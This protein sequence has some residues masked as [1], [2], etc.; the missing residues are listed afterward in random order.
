[1]STILAHPYRPDRASTTHILSNL[2]PIRIE[3][4][5]KK[6]VVRASLRSD[7]PEVIDNYYKQLGASDKALIFWL[8]DGSIHDRS[9]A[10]VKEKLL[11]NI[12]SEKIDS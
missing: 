6:F 10:K 1:M 11:G 4:N 5:G 2:S 9:L 12:V 3:V 7:C 8:M